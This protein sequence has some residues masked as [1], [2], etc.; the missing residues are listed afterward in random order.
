MITSGKK[1]SDEL[2]MLASER[3]RIEKAEHHDPFTYLGRHQTG[4]QVIVRVFAPGAQRIEIMESGISLERLTGSDFFEWSGPTHQVPERYR[5]RRVDKAGQASVYYDPYCFPPQ[6]SDYD[7]HLFAQ[8]KHW[9][10]YRILG[11][12]QRTCDGVEGVLFAAWAPNAARVS[13]VGNFNDWDGRKHPMRVRGENGVWELFIPGL[14]PGALYKYEV[15]NRDTTQVFL[16]AD[17]Y[18][19]HFEIAPDTANLV[20]TDTIHR[21]RDQDW[22]ERR[23]QWDWLHAPIAIY[24]V[25]AGSWRRSETNRPLDYRDL[26]DQLVP[27]VADLGY[28][29]IE[30][31]PITEH[32]F[33]GSWG[34]QTVGYFASTSRHG[35]QAD[36]RYFI[37]L[38]HQ[39]NIGVLLDWPPAHFPK[40]PYALARYDGTA[41]YEHSDPRRGEHRDWGTLIFNYGRNEVANF[42]LS[43][44][45]YWL[46]E[47]HFDGLRVDAVAS[48]LYLDY[49]R[50]EGD[51]V[52]NKYGGRENLEAIDFLRQLNEVVHEQFPGVI[53]TAEE[54]TAWPMVSRPVYVGG[55]GFSMKWNM[56]WMNDTL[57]Y[58]AL[59]SVHRKYHH[60]LLTFSQLYCF[61]EN[62]VL[63][64]SHDEV[65][66]GKRSLLY[67]MPGDEWQRLAN[68]RLLYTYQYTHPGK[69]LLFMGSEFAQG[70][71]WSHENALEW[72]VLQF[73]G[74]AGV[75]RL[76]RDLNTLYR[77]S[78]P[79][80]HF[81]FDPH[82]FEWLDC[83]DTEQ[84]VLSYLRKDEDGFVV[85]VLNFTPVVR[86]QY[87]VGVPEPGPYR[88]IFN[89][90]SEHY[91]GSNVG[92]SGQVDAQPIPWMGQ[93]H[94][95]S[96]TLPPLAGIVLKPV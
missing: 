79:L 11:A 29:H 32:P 2:K 55:L 88:E 13:V 48:M 35:P 30:L 94:S 86:N 57:S 72:Y 96:L 27:Y 28:T 16:K 23:E 74:H 70:S 4:D 53:V 83:H 47:F 43:S 6:L 93:R 33:E 90:D 56:G 85:V 78:R 64:F 19:R 69:K 84:S 54:S 92:N 91:G 38:C 62:F 25:H 77:E 21:W 41:L 18:G 49:S 44:A 65:V 14:E 45:V 46:E 63:P 68:V 26:A 40:D 67:K 81:D 5:L 95:I 61:T 42:L 71:E 8:G 58:F 66:H 31:L 75:K 3:E 20:P 89:S 80:H 12:R 51:W 1:L 22:M 7:L 52:P 59:D 82:G 76:V 9:H 10:I 87:R 24:E 17:P 34:Y 15:R 73:G 37:D 36:L 60:E 50:D 39:N